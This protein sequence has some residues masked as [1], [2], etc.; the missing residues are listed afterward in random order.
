MLIFVQV[1]RTIDKNLVSL[2]SI[3]SDR[4]NEGNEINKKEAWSIWRKRFWRQAVM[5]KLTSS[6]AVHQ[7][8][9]SSEVLK[10]IRSWKT[11]ELQMLFKWRLNHA[12]HCRRLEE[13]SN[14]FFKWIW[15]H[16]MLIQLR[17]LKK[18]ICTK[19]TTIISTTLFLCLL[20]QEQQLCLQRCSSRFGMDL[21]LILHMTITKSDKRSL[22]I[23]SSFKR[24]YLM[25]WKFPTYLSHLNKKEWRPAVW[26]LKTLTTILLVPKLCWNCFTS[27]VHLEFLIKVHILE[28]LES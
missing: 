15:R 10:I 5:K 11:E 17:A 6:E 21:K 28:I 19:C 13:W 2:W 22:V 9:T 16:W 14:G 12:H 26:K 23:W 3:G 20:V 1:C 8:L 25:C 24:L 4:T 18:D 7:K 27:K